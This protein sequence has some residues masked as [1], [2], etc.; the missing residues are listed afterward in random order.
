M[1][2]DTGR[3]MSQLGRRDSEWMIEGDERRTFGKALGQYMEEKRIKKQELATKLW[4]SPF[5]EDETVAYESVMTKINRWLSDRAIPED[6]SLIFQL[7]I[8]LELSGSE[9]RDLVERALM[10]SWAHTANQNELIYEFCIDNSLG[11]MAAWRL[12]NTDYSS[13]K[14]AGIMAGRGKTMTISTTRYIGEKYSLWSKSA[15]ALPL[16]RKMEAFEEFLRANQP[17]FHTIR[18]TR[19]RLFSSMVESFKEN[20]RKITQL[21]ERIKDEEGT[22]TMLADRLRSMRLPSAGDVENIEKAD[23]RKRIDK[24][25]KEDARWGDNNPIRKDIPLYR[26]GKKDIPRD[27]FIKMYLLTQDYADLYDLEALLNEAGY[28]SIYVRASDG[29]DALVYHL[30]AVNEA[31][32]IY[33]PYYE[34]DYLDA[35]KKV[36][37]RLKE[38]AHSTD[39]KTPPEI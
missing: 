33:K 3:V 16:E 15:E 36:L 11:I 8:H 37:K 17:Y 26:S 7:C 24:I 14:S 29:F 5:N 18:A 1:S 34:G 27:I 25:I 39:T 23:S 20:E 35:V 2:K 38:Q 28:P 32:N 19:I 4:T 30:F 10:A 21:D 9:A 12:I 13:E 22:N 6:R 31:E